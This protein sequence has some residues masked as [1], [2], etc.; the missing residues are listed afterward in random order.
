MRNI[1]RARGPVITRPL[2]LSAIP[3]RKASRFPARSS[4]A[5][6]TT[7]STI[8]AA[9]WAGPVDSKALNASNGGSLH[10]NRNN[11]LDFP[12]AY[13]SPD[14]GLQYTARFRPRMREGHDLRV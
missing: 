4:H 14:S 6:L 1:A 7:P 9:A 8:R 10:D 11:L 2:S 13:S 12:E 3:V 5:G